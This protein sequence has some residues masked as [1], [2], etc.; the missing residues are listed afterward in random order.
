MNH[1]DL[2]LS[3]ASLR[4]LLFDTR[5]DPLLLAFLKSHNLTI[6]VDTLETNLGMFLLS[7]LV[8]GDSHV[9]DLWMNV[10]LNTNM[11]SQF[12]IDKRSQF[13]IAFN[14]GA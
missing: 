3:A 5:G 7:W 6:V 10:L 11:H 8:P 1:A 4:A 12:S 2:L 9:S 13:V 14:K